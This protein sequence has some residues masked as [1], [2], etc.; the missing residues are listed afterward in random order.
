M[1]TDGGFQ[2]SVIHS[3][4]ENIKCGVGVFECNICFDLAEDPVVTL[5]GHLFCWPCL[6]KWLQFHSYSHECPVCKAFVDKDNLV[7]IYG[8]GASSSDLSANLLSRSEIPS[9][10]ASQRPQT[11]RAPELSYFRQDGHGARGRSGF[12]SMATTSLGDLTRSVL[13]DVISSVSNFQAHDF[14][15]SGVDYLLSSYVHGGNAHGIHRYPINV[16]GTKVVF[17]TICF[18][19]FGLVASVMIILS[20][21]FTS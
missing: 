15:T 20:S 6:Y 8:R 2:E 21:L 18:L 11:A 1:N 16:Q 19:V 9:R 13:V 12:M 3:C 4:S 5:C 14:H 17:L 7:P 10:P